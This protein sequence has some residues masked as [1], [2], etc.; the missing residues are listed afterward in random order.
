MRLHMRQKEFYPYREGENRVK[1]S[2][3]FSDQYSR[4]KKRRKGVRRLVLTLALLLALLMF[5]I[6]YIMNK[7]NEYKANGG[8]FSSTGL[9]ASSD[10][11]VASGDTKTEL[12]VN[13]A[14]FELT[15][16]DKINIT[17]REKDGKVEFVGTEGHKD[18]YTYDISPDKSRIIINENTEGT[19]FL[20][21]K[22][23]NAKDLSPTEFT[24]D[25]GSVIQR[26]DYA[27]QEGFIW[28]Q[29]A[30]F[31]DNNDILFK[32]RLNED[33]N[34]TVIRGMAVNDAESTV[35]NGSG[36]KVIELVRITPQ[37]YL[38]RI[39]GVE[40][41]VDTNFRFTE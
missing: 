18:L 30:V 37:G 16:G 41:T 28:A 26:K 22:N 40:K 24:L 3:I 34:K 31:M 36:G 14:E 9:S 20:I 32:S 29:G 13:A 1:K 27:H 17:Y 39:D 10:T 19:I 11:T 12:P 5:M 2:S 6:P 35:V 33:L 15:G 25:N 7:V 8:S 23:F 21:D 38:V 4:E